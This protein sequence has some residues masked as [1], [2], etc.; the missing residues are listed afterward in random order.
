ME[1]ARGAP[2]DIWAWALMSLLAVVL[3]TSRGKKAKIIE[4]LKNYEEPRITAWPNPN[5]FRREGILLHAHRFRCHARGRHSVGDLSLQRNRALLW[6]GNGVELMLRHEQRA[7]PLPG[8]FGRPPLYRKFRR[9]L[10]RSIP[11]GHFGYGNRSA[12]W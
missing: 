12:L 3:L 2:L 6:I 7:L 8:Y 5:Y 9:E 10:A 11:F 1:G 4:M